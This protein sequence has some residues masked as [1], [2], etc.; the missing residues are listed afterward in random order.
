M[1]S[2]NNTSTWIRGARI[3]LVCGVMLGLAVAPSLFAQ[4][5]N[6]QYRPVAQNQMATPTNSSASPNA[7][8]AQPS[9]NATP[10]DDQTQP[11]AQ[12]DQNQPATSAPA[13]DS[14]QQSDTS[15]TD[16]DQSLPKTASDLP[17]AGLIALLSLG[18]AALIHTSRRIAV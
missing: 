1:K 2:T 17:L 5:N 18:S 3:A 16:N 15:N 7:Q 12:Q 11:A 13:P 10:N 14:Q 9:P 6:Q 8:P 4:S